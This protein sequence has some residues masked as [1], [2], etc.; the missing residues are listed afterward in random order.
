MLEK[1]IFKRRLIMK[2]VFSLILTLV[3]VAVTL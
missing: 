1:F 2:K 3:L